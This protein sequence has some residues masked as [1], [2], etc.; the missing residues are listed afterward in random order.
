MSSAAPPK[1]SSA[2]TWWSRSRNR[3]QSNAR[4]LREGQVLFTYLHLAPDPEQAQGPG[5]QRC[6]LH[7]LRNGHV[8]LR[9]PAA[10]CADERSGRTARGAGRRALPREIGR[11][12]GHA[13]RRRAGRG[14]GTHRHSRRRRGRHELRADG[15]R[16]RR[17][18]GRHRQVDR[19]P[20]AHRR[21]VQRPRDHRVL[22]P[23]QCRARGAARGSRDLRRA[24][25]R[26]RSAQARSRRPC[27]RK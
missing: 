12:H 18:G 13:A 10:A 7:C 11:R 14:A 26:R 23:G 22:E 1:S 8:A 24:D 19:C 3:R 21:D 5:R 9:R 27:C 15:R 16:H 17:T 2:P 4:Q 20:A 6:D 25:S